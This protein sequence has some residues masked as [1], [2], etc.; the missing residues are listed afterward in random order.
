MKKFTPVLFLCLAI[1]CYQPT[2]A[3]DLLVLGNDDLA[4]ATMVGALPFTNTVLSAD[5]AMATGEVDE[6]ECLGTTESWWYEFTTPNF[7]NDYIIKAEV[8]GSDNED[9]TDDLVLGIYTGSNHPL[10]EVACIDGDNGDGWGEDIL[11]SLDASTT[12]YI[13]V[14]A[15]DASLIQ[16]VTFSLNF[17][18]DWDG[19]ESTNWNDGDNWSTGMA[20]VSTSVVFINGGVPND[21]IIDGI[22][23]AEAGIVIIINDGNL[24]IQNGGSL[25]IIST[26]EDA[27][28]VDDP[29][30]TLTINGSL[31]TSGQSDNGI[32]VAAGNLQIGA[33][34][35]VN[36]SDTEFGIDI[37]SNSANTHNI[38]GT[39]NISNIS[40]DGLS[41]LR[42]VTVTIGPNAMIDIDGIGL[43]GIFLN[44]N[45]AL[46]I[47]RGMLSISNTDED[48]IEV[49]R[50]SLR[51]GE[52]G[53][54]DIDEVA[55]RGM[56]E[57][58]GR[59]N[60]TINISNTGGDGMNTGNDVFRNTSTGIINISNCDSDG[61]DCDDDFNNEGLVSINNCIA[62]VIQDPTFNNLATGT[63]RA[64]GDVEAVNFTFSSGSTLEPGSSPGCLNFNSDED[65]SGVNFDLE[66]EGT[67]ACTQYDQVAVEGTVSL[68]NAVLNLSGAYAPMDGESF[69]LI[70]NNGS[71]DAVI[72]TFTGLAEGAT[73]IFNNA[74]LGISYQG[75]D[76]NDVVL[77]V[78]TVLPV[79]LISFKVNAKDEAVLLEWATASET[80]NDH[81]IVERSANGKQFLPLTKIKAAGT[82]LETQ[83]YNFL[84]ESPEKAINY[85][86]L[87]QVDTDGT[88][89]YSEIRVVKM[90]HTVFKVHPNPVEDFLYYE[91]G[92]E[93]E[94]QRLEL[95]DQAG[96]LVK[97]IRTFNRR[98]D[99]NGVE[100][101]IYSLIVITRTGRHELQILKQ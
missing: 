23:M 48:G 8:L 7:T 1:F 25:S 45:N 31:T 66:I 92:E 30:S 58:V 100:S 35:L 34:A 29:Q 60:G 16:D 65:F 97:S 17:V 32:E 36:I 75:G 3:S 50:G 33:N 85:Y 91:L 61:I 46:L 37:F 68:T 15:R 77:T 26:E 57:V 98:I 39:V 54:I 52:N 56:N 81:F 18:Y 22:T 71:A 88:F 47:V 14:A 21:A 78:I 67:S 38:N 90:D 12:Y 83:H 2:R 10:I 40:G 74:E 20:P 43:D 6:V 59:N 80:N 79:E 84:D 82:T 42:N 96:R 63:L 19:S 4:N 69:V 44:A 13:R 93:Q 27:I 72:G 55:E 89:D 95:Y 5:A 24:T 62:F 87:K 64:D 73:F 70:D 9:D 76:G 86:R 41:I 28:V 53:Q 101:G 49:A 94:L 99:L 51:V 11:I